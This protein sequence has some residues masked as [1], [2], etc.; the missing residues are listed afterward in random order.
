MLP[1]QFVRVRLIGAEYKDA[2]VI[3]SSALVNTASGAIVYTVGDDKI[4]KANK[5]TA[6]FVGDDVIVDSGLKEGDVVV[7]EGIVKVR[8]G[9]SVN[10]V[11][12]TTEMESNAELDKK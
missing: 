2:L 5:V 4:V 9:V 12:K 1:G 10:A 7:S 3:P 8:P 6:E 11:L